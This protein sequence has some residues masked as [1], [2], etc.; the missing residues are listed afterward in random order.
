MP[1]D[2]NPARGYIVTA[3][4]AVVESGTGAG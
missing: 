1:Y 2:Y 4:Q 3:N